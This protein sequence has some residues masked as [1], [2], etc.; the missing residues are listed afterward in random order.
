MTRYVNSPRASARKKGYPN[1]LP[2]VQGVDIPAVGKKF[3]EKDRYRGWVGEESADARKISAIRWKKKRN[4]ALKEPAWDH[5]RK[6]VTL[7]YL[8]C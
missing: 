6:V 8:A 3:L 7:G 4:W 5:R 1:T 2:L